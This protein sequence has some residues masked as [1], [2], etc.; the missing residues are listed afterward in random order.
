M[1]S[2]LRKIGAYLCYGMSIL[3]FLGVVLGERQYLLGLPGWVSLGWILD[4]W[5]D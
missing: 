3:V 4:G 2:K 1:K 5:A